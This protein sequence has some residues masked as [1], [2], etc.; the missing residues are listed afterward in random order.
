MLG[1]DGEGGEGEQPF[2]DGFLET[3]DLGYLMEDGRLVLEGRVDGI[4]KS[5]GRRI[6]AA[7]IERAALRWPGVAAA[8][9]IAVPCPARG[10]RPVLFVEP[11]GRPG[12]LR[13]LEAVLKRELEGYKVPREIVLVEALPRS[14][15]GKIAARELERLWREGEPLAE[16]GR[17]PLGCRF[18]RLDVSAPL[19]G[20]RA[21]A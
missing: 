19:S 5:Y 15:T 13:E 18:R 12:E 6:A 8:R 1:Y 3:G 4:F 7:E 2:R 16:L 10:M 21:L 11:E 14:A 17:G 9:C 20:R